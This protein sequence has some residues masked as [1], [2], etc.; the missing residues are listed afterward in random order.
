MCFDEFGDFVFL[1]A[2]AINVEIPVHDINTIYFRDTILHVDQF[3]IRGDGQL[4]ELFPL[5]EMMVI[6]GVHRSKT[7]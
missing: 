1:V 3:P 4:G 6:L 2:P 7:F 5:E